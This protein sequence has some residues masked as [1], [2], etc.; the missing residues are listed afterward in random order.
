MLSSIRLHFDALNESKK[1]NNEKKNAKL[2]L[3]RLF[4]REILFAKTLIVKI[5]RTLR[6]Q[7][8]FGVAVT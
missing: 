4:R 7:S 2:K 1:G 3:N 5:L 8:I 6:M